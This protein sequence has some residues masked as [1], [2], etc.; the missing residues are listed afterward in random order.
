MT[1]YITIAFFDGLN[2]CKYVRKSSNPI[3][4]LLEF[5]L[6]FITR[7]SKVL[8]FITFWN[9]PCE[10]SNISIVSANFPSKAVEWSISVTLTGISYLFI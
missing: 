6:Y 4:T 8:L 1:L 5:G 7:D 10:G 3:S 9:L 2:F